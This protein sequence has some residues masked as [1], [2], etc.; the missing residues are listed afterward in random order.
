MPAEATPTGLLGDTAARDYSHK[1]E[2][3]NAFA[4]PE[5]RMAINSLD[6]KPGMRILDAGCGS[7][8][9]LS[10]LWDAVGPGGEVAGIDLSEAHVATARRR[11]P[12]GARVCRAD[13]A[14]APFAP[15][16]FDLVWC[17]NTINHLRAPVAGIRALARLVIPG[18]RIAL[19]Q[20]SLVPEMHFAWDARLERL[21][22]EAVRQYYRDRYGLTEHDLRAVRAIVGLLRQAGLHAVKSCTLMHERVAPLD[23]ASEAFLV[24]A[25]FRDTWGERLRPYLQAEDFAE[26]AELCN[27]RHANFALHRADFHFLQSF[28]LAVGKVTA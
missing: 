1:L 11:A 9:A 27:P 7:G 10:W 3:F 16:T 28:T 14:Q 25:I 23:P 12:H 21:T 13:I 22:N 19:G 17:V 20:S 5:L 6:L 2:L 15:A 26:L 8:E 18:G 24:E 4:E